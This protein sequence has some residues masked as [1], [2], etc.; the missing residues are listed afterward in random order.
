MLEK[1][2]LNR[3][4]LGKRSQASSLITIK[5]QPKTFQKRKSQVRYQFS[6]TNHP[7]DTEVNSQKKKKT[8]ILIDNKTTD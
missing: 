5:E 2:C 8:R 1:Y 6:S 7:Q 3:V 4:D